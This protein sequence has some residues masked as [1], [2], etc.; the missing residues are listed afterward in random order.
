MEIGTISEAEPQHHG[1]EVGKAVTVATGPNSTGVWFR[2]MATKSLSC[3]SGDDTADCGH[4]LV[5]SIGQAIS[6]MS[7]ASCAPS[8]AN[9][10]SGNA[11]MTPM[12]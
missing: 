9:D 1:T 11:H 5:P 6:L 2:S 10:R 7:S 4:M 3:R 8:F 12:I